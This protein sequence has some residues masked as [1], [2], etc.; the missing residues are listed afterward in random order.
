MY[1]PRISHVLSAVLAA[2][3]IPGDRIEWRG[4]AYRA[5]RGGALEILEEEK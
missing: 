1:R 3:I 5:H 4:Q 2:L